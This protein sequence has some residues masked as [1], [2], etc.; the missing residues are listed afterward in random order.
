MVSKY[1]LKR[2]SRTEVVYGDTDSVF[3]KFGRYKDDRLLEGK[4]ALAHCIQCGI[5]AVII[6]QREILVEEKMD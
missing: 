5:E 2:I 3:V 1:G 6:L 4:E